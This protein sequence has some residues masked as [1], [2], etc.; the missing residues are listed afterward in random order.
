LNLVPNSGFDSITICPSTGGEMSY[1]PP[2]IDPTGASS[3]LIN[4]CSSNSYCSAPNNSHG[5]QNPYNG[6]GMAGI[7]TYA[8]SVWANDLREYIQVKLN[9]TLKS[10]KYYCVSFYYSWAD[11]SEFASDALGA[12]F[13][14]QPI[15]CIGC[16]FNYSP[17]L[18]NAANNV[19]TDGQNW[20]ELAGSFIAQ[21]GEQYITIGSFKTDN[22]SSIQTINSN[23]SYILAYYFID[24]VSV[25]EIATPLAGFDT[26]ICPN[27]SV[28]LG[29]ISNPNCIYSWQPSTGLSDSTISNPLASPSVTTTYTLTQTQCNVVQ[30][31]SVTV[32]V[33]TD[34]NPVIPFFIPS[35]IKGDEMLTIP[36]LET[37]SRITVFDAMG[38]RVF[39]SENY[40]NEF[41][42][43]MVAMGTYIVQLEKADGEMVRQKLV[44]VR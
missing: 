27:D 17:Q 43:F 24:N 31:A 25:I 41:G 40:H 37:G 14:Q 13:S 1:A 35:I 5:W 26:Q 11:S 21:G 18:S 15:S 23:A 33:K 30:T 6:D 29:T 2:W 36:G 22:Q 7:A 20:V 4:Q 34:C 3:D 42:G 19:L 12:Y 10:G 16:L 9:D 28:S 39:I 8:D 32:T 44:V 38:K